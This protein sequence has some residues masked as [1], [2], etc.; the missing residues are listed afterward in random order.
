MGL[1]D[2]EFEKRMLAYGQL[3][4]FLIAFI[5]NVN[6][7]NLD[8]LFNQNLNFC[9][10][11]IKI[12]REMRYIVIKRNFLENIMDVELKEPTENGFFYEGKKSFFC[13]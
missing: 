13:K 2:N 11:N 7:Q 5:A 9:F 10:V 6:C 1:Q 3:N 12:L 8:K 4:R